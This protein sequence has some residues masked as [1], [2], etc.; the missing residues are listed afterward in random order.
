MKIWEHI[1]KIQEKIIDWTLMIV[2]I[3]WY[4][5]VI[6]KIY[7]NCNVQFYKRFIYVFMCL[8]YFK[9]TSEIETLLMKHRYCQANQCLTILL[10]IH[11]PNFPIYL[12]S[13]FPLCKLLNPIW[14]SLNR[15]IHIHGPPKACHSINCIKISSLWYYWHKFRAC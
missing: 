8:L 2:Y 14:N 3:L 9:Y 6:R 11:N 10:F 4:W 7:I 5:L 13:H 15:N 12:L 1:P